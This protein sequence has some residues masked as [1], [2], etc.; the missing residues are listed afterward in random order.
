MTARACIP[1]PPPED[2]DRDTDV[3]ALACDGCDTTADEPC[4]A[5][6]PDG[7]EMAVYWS[8]GP[9]VGT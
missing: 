2:G 4:A 8:A 3:D 6:C 5:W 9:E 1:P 7:G